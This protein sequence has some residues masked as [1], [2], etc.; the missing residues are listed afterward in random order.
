MMIVK[1]SHLLYIIKIN[2]TYI[3]IIII[4]IWQSR[5]IFGTILKKHAMNM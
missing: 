4:F 3:S 2:N 5:K 1:V